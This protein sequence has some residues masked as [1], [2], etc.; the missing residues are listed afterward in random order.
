MSFFLPVRKIGNIICMAKKDL[1]LRCTQTKVFIEMRYCDSS[2]NKIELYLFDS[3]YI[4]NLFLKNKSLQVRLL[5]ST[6]GW[7]VYPSS[8]V[9]LAKCVGNH[10]RPRSTYRISIFLFHVYYT[11]YGVLCQYLWAKI[12]LRI[13]P[14]YRY[15]YAFVIL[16]L[17]NQTLLIYKG[18]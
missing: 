10:F 14:T 12:I 8:Q 6:N 4:F 5:A 15:V 3:Y 9:L 16:T 18:S 13:L 17:V 1:D 2:W 7:A 11:I